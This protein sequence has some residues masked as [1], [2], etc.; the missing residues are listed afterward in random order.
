MHYK[1]HYELSKRRFVKLFTSSPLVD[2]VHEGAYS[3]EHSKVVCSAVLMIPAHSAS[4]NPSP[5]LITHKWSATV[6]L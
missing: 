3:S 5:T 6:S 2:P 4:E 1:F